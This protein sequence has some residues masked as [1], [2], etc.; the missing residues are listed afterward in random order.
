MDQFYPK[1]QMVFFSLLG[2]HRVSELD[3]SYYGLIYFLL[4]MDMVTSFIHTML[5]LQVNLLL[6]PFKLSIKMLLE[7]L[8]INCQMH[9]PFLLMMMDQVILLL[10]MKL[11][12]SIMSNNLLLILFTHCLRERLAHKLDLE[13]M[14]EF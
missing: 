4:L 10:L 9:L 13:I 7:F 6:V 2:L 5:L 12:T 3:F 8:T 1:D 11:H 14:K